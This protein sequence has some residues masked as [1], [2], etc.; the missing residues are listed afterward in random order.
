MLYRQYIS[1]LSE[2]G[3]NTYGTQMLHETVDDGAFACT[4]A[5]AEHVHIGAK[6]PHDVFMPAPQTADFDVLNVVGQFYHK[7]NRIELRLSRQSPGS[8]MAGRQSSVFCHTTNVGKT[9]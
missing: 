7:T 8:Y 1:H 4:V 2:L 9:D 5:A 3:G 6:G